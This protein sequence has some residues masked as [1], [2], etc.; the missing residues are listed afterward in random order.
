MRIGD[1]ET[2]VVLSP[3]PD[4]P[5]AEIAALSDEH[6][7]LAVNGARMSPGT[8]SREFLRAMPALSRTGLSR[9]SCTVPV[10][11]RAPCCW[12]HVTR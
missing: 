4:R 9:C 6:D 8:G 7:H 12:R 1:L 3:I 5:E 10:C 11:P 2:P